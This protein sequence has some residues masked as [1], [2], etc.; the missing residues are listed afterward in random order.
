MSFM[1]RELTG[2][3]AGLPTAMRYNEDPAI[4]SDIVLNSAK[5]EIFIFVDICVAKPTPN[6]QTVQKTTEVPQTQCL[7]R[8]M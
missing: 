7:S 1:H 8:H 4:F 5:D 3:S 2:P 6:I